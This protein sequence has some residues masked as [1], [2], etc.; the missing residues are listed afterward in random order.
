M[1]TTTWIPKTPGRASRAHRMVREQL[2]DLAAKEASLDLNA[3]RARTDNHLRAMLTISHLIAV[4]R[5]RLTERLR[6]L[7]LEI[8]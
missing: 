8:N 3:G 2:E 7:A 1:Q 5:A 6:A 4:E